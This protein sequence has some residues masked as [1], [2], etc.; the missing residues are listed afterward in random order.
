MNDND[1]R[2]YDTRLV[3]I[4]T[5]LAFQ[6]DMVHELNKTVYLQQKKIEQMEATITQLQDRVKSISN[7]DPQKIDPADEIPPHY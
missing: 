5:K 3:D 1:N 6:E 4:E 7:P 2:E